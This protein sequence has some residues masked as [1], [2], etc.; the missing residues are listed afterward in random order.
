MCDERICMPQLGGCVCVCVCVCAR[1]CGICRF[2]SGLN[3]WNKH[4]LRGGLT[5][6]WA[7]LGVVC[8]DQ[9]SMGHPLKWFV[10]HMQL[11]LNTGLSC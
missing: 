8:D 7:D 2:E 9:S 1:A 4:W 3:A 10:V 6:Q 11:P 5:S